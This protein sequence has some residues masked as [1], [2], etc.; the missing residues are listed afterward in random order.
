M[1]AAAAL[2]CLVAA[3]CV[4]AAAAAAVAISPAKSLRQEQ[5][6]V[7]S[8]AFEQ[9]LLVCNAYPSKSGMSV[10]KND[11]DNLA[12]GKDTIPFRECRYLPSQLQKQDRLDFSLEEVVDH[13]TFDVGDLPSSDAVLLLVVEKKASSPMLAFQSY[14][15]PLTSGRKEAQIAVINAVSDLDSTV[16][17]LKMNDHIDT[18]EAQTVAK[19]VEQLSFNRVYSVEEGSYDASVA[20]SANMVLSLAGSQN[21][22]LLRTGGNG[23]NSSLLL[24]PN[25][26]SQA[27][28]TGLA[29]LKETIQASFMRLFGKK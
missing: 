18:K 4:S 19:R 20:D 25:T 16:P 23:Y 12:G 6:L 15:F 24:F 22:V 29:W 11:H 28:A 14:A 17:K 13:G 9:K 5:S 2:V 3:C 10:V 26:D 21:Y 27:K 1:S 8:I 7:R